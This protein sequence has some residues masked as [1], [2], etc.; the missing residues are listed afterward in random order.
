MSIILVLCLVLISVQSV[1]AQQ[2]G[3]DSPLEGSVQSGNVAPPT[4]WTCGNGIVTASVNGGPTINFTEDQ[5]RGDTGVPC[6][7]TGDNAF[8]IAQPWNWNVLGSGQHTIVFFLNGAQFATRTFTVATFGTEFLFGPSASFTV[9]DFPDPGHEA[10]YRQVIAVKGDLLG[11]IDDYLNSGRHHILIL[12]DSGMGKTSFVLN[13]YAY[14]QRKIQ[15]DRWR[16]AVVP[17]GN[18]E[19]GSRIKTPYAPSPSSSR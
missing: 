16:L 6:N 3:I 17:L 1:F 9:Q 4:G 10:E 8:I 2:F 7:N 13:Y 11:T 5:N 15:K 19:N 12:A 14:N 18:P